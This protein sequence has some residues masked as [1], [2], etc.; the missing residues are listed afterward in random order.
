MNT[1]NQFQY[2]YTNLSLY[3]FNADWFMVVIV[4]VIAAIFMVILYIIMQY[5]AL[6]NISYHA[7]RALAHKK[8]TL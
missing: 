4:F 8:K 6:Y 3:Q 2:I 1:F 5:G 7:D